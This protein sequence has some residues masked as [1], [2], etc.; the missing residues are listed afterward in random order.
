VGCSLIF[1]GTKGAAGFCKELCLSSNSVLIIAIIVIVTFVILLKYSW[2]PGI[3][4]WV[5]CVL[6][7]IVFGSKHDWR[8]SVVQLSKGGEGVFISVIIVGIVGFCVG[9]RESSA[10]SYVSVFTGI[11][12]I[13]GSIFVSSIVER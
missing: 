12:R 11:G 3:S 10:A 4:A 2:Q 7:A 1:V 9:I 8:G 6:A 13:V 5:C